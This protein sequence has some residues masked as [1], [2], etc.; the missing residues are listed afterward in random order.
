MVERPLSLI[1]K[2]MYLEHFVGRG[3]SYSEFISSDIV[4][5]TVEQWMF[6]LEENNIDFGYNP[7]HN[8]PIII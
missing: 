4:K 6:L 3:L 5:T 2:E 8:F 1:K 7:E